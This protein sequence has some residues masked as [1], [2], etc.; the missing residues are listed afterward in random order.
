MSIDRTKRPPVGPAVPVKFPAIDRTTLASGLRVWS[1][2]R[3]D[4]PIVS[5]Q[6]LLPSGAAKDPPNDEGLA[7]LT[8]DLLD[9]GTRVRSAF[10]LHEL[11]ARLGAQLDTQVGSDSTVLSILTLSRHLGEAISLLAEVWGRPRFAADDVERVRQ[12]R[13]SRLR[14]L[15]D[16]A[17]AVAER[18]FLE[19]LYG[20]HPYAH[21]ALGSESSVSSLTGDEVQHFHSRE[22]QPPQATLIVAGDVAHNDVTAFAD[23]A[24]SEVASESLATEPG[25][26]A[27]PP[28]V[29]P[30]GRSGRVIFVHRPNAPQSEVRVGR[31][32]APRSTLDY[33]RLLVLN[34]VAGGQFVSRINTNLREVKGYTYGARSAFE[35]RKMP[36]P[37]AVQTSVQ[38]DAT[39][40][41]IHEILRDLGGL[42]GSRPVEPEEL[43]RARASLTRGYPRGFE[44][45]EQIGRAML[46]LALHHLPD[47]SFDQFVPSVEAVD[48]DAVTTAAK[49]YLDPDTMSVIVVGDRD[50][51]RPQLESQ[52]LGTPHEVEIPR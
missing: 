42:G 49:Q 24:F 45:A 12:I 43:T 33:H 37:F 6:L 20:T 30:E 15:R 21:T 52:G 1:V 51:V 48:A 11:L 13:L 3:R 14:Q 9:E 34:A 22:Y 5:L 27:T 29:I 31:I 17:G 16:I 32:G 19:H 41:T 35:F 25:P 39:G 2:T 26:A 38:T 10:E 36:G 46:S 47:D 50:Q 28:S 7:A 44:T 4:L 23:R 40:A 8:A 18:V